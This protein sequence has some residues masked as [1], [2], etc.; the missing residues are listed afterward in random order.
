M[1]GFNPDHAGFLLKGA[2]NLNKSPFRGWASETLH[3]L[4]WLKAEKNGGIDHRFQLVL[5]ISSIH[6]AGFVS[7]DLLT[8]VQ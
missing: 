5:R 7:L 1:D 6:R 2:Q 4:G 8:V 3:H